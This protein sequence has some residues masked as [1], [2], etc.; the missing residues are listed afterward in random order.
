MTGEYQI[1]IAFGRGSAPIQADPALAD[2][3]VIRPS[4]EAT[5][6]GAAEKFRVAARNP[7]G[8]AP[9]RDV[10]KPSDR[11]VIVTS[12]GTRAVPNRLLIPWILEELPVPEDRVTV[13]LGNGTHRANTDEEI[14]GMFG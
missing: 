12:D 5:L 1:D 10:V 11:V 7:T 4:F 6:P 14:A 2:W 13:L 9:L 3:Q 8:S